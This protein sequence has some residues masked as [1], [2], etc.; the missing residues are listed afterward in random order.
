M[1]PAVASRMGSH[2][3]SMKFFEQFSVFVCKQELRRSPENQAKIKK[4]KLYQ[5][6]SA[7]LTP[8]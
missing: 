1:S 4:I 5:L 2:A 8:R 6:I 3:L 7:R